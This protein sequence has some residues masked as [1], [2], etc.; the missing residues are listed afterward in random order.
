M[1][2]N[3]FFLLLFIC[4]FLNYVKNQDDIK[5]ECNLYTNPQIPKHDDIDNKDY[6]CMGKDFDLNDN[7]RCCFVK[8][9]DYKNSNSFNSCIFFNT[10]DEYKQM[11]KNYK[12]LGVKHLD[13]DC[14]ENYLK[15]LFKLN[16]L[17]SV[18]LF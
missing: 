9:K 3:K 15:I 10:K 5:K 1:N 14:N 13:I 16:L 12:K 7:N 17:L 8:F 18:I 6:D 2:K 4:F 11:K